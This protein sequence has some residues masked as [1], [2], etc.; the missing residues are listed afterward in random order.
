MATKCTAAE[1]R[2]RN[3]PEAPTR[4]Q[5]MQTLLRTCAFEV[6]VEEVAKRQ[7][8]TKFIEFVTADFT[9]CKQTYQ[10]LFVS[11]SRM[12]ASPIVASSEGGRAKFR[13]PSCDA[14]LGR[15]LAETA[16]VAI[17][18]IDCYLVPSDYERQSTKIAI[19]YGKTI[20][21]ILDS[22]MPAW[23]PTE[24]PQQPAPVAEAPQ[25]DAAAPTPPAAVVEPTTPSAAPVAVEVPV[26]TPEQAQILASETQQQSQPP[27]RRLNFAPDFDWNA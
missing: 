20:K 11:K 19:R 8:T 12:L 9:D 15:V 25:S 6:G 13:V 16:K 17:G 23:T 14:F 26:I 10:Q 5:L 1:A 3:N 21:G 22:S 2:I 27:A 18:C 24:A 4:L 7:M